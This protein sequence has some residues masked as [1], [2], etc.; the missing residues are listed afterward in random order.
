MSHDRWS[1]RLLIKPS[2][3][4]EPASPPAVDQHINYKASADHHRS[5]VCGAESLK[6]HDHN[7]GGTNS[8]SQPQASQH[9]PYRSLPC[10]QRR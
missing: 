4:A 3:R 1:D 10:S 8:A 2:G 5:M 6:S 7:R 9:E